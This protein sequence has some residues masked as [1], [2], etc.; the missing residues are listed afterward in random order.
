MITAMKEKKGGQH[1][2]LLKLSMTLST[3]SSR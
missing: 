1:M 2:Q 3:D